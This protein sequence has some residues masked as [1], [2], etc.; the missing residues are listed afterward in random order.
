MTLYF[1]YLLL[2]NIC[3]GLLLLFAVSR[4]LKSAINIHLAY[5]ILFLY[6]LSECLVVTYHPQLSGFLAAVSILLI[7]NLL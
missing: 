4:C 5:V 7:N 2:V 1:E 3:G 6:K